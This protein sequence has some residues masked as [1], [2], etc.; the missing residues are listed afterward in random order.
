MSKHGWP[1]S[2]P[3]PSDGE[4]CIAPPGP[5]RDQAATLRH[6]TPAIA[7]L[8]TVRGSGGVGAGRADLDGLELSLERAVHEVAREALA[9]VLQRGGVL[10]EDEVGA[11]AQQEQ[12]LHA[13]S[14]LATRRKAASWL[15]RA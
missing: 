8:D 1:C 5:P 4:S 15:R 12:L 10:F 6:W 2:T 11:A 14:A 13:P 9:D 7:E 3:T